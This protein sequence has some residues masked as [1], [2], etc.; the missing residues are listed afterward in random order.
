MITITNKINIAVVHRAYE[1][2]HKS[3][4]GFTGLIP[5]HV[6]KQAIASRFFME[7]AF[8]FGLFIKS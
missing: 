2:P 1:Q 4:Y 3:L 5:E 7:A 8:F 6:Q